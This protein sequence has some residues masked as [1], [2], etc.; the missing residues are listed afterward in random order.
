VRR[1]EVA[2]ARRV[3]GGCRWLNTR[4]RLTR[5]RSCS[6]PR[7]LRARGTDRWRYDRRT[8]LPGG[9]YLVLT[10]ARDRAGNLQGRPARAGRR[11]R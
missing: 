4:G 10:R 1:V 2:L 5:P 6:R 11:V 8:R 7:W 3:R 9:T